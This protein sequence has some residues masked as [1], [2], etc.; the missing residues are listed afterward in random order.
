MRIELIS[1]LAVVGVVRGYSPK[2]E[3]AIKEEVG[4]LN[5]Y[6]TTVVSTDLSHA[7]ASLDTTFKTTEK[8]IQESLFENLRNAQ[9]VIDAAC[10]DESS[11]PRPR[12]WQ[13]A[14]FTQL[15]TLLEVAGK[16]FKVRDAFMQVFGVGSSWKPAETL[17]D[18]EEQLEKV[19]K[20]TKTLLYFRNREFDQ[21]RSNRMFEPMMGVVSEEF[22]KEFGRL[23]SLTET[24]EEQ[25]E[26]LQKESVLPVGWK[27]PACR[28]AIAVE[29]K[30]LLEFMKNVIEPQVEMDIAKMYL[31]VDEILDNARKALEKP[32]AE[33]SERVGLVCNQAGY[34]PPERPQVFAWLIHREFGVFS[35]AIEL[36]GKLRKSIS[37]LSSFGSLWRPTYSVSEIDSR[38]DQARAA[39]RSVVAVKFYRTNRMLGPLVTKLIDLETQ[40]KDR[41][42]SLIRKLTWQKQEIE[43]QHVNTYNQQLRR[44]Y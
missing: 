27:F 4:K 3:Q 32:L 37:D 40:A 31:S 42:E 21:F 20:A 44:N 15:G 12:D 2:C 38:L 23:N 26:E 8:K 17:K 34:Q 36:G 33:A 24:L 30:K 41:V 39:L 7:L 29:T 10:K 25:R 9:T 11:P 19:E 16:G 5:K 22:R 14:T 6:I 13:E 43:N 35:A 1:A 28:E 18:N